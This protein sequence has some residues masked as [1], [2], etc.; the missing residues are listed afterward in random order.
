MAILQKQIDNSYESA[1]KFSDFV[2]MILRASLCCA[3]TGYLIRYAVLHSDNTNVVVWIAILSV[4]LL[5]FACQLLIFAGYM[6]H[7]FLVDY[8]GMDKKHSALSA[9][10]NFVFMFLLIGIAA[11]AFLSGISFRLG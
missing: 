10:P 6:W 4:I 3:I 9:V 1:K 7:G 2:A 5:G 8:F 11:T